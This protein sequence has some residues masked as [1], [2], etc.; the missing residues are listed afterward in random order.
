[1]DVILYEEF[2]QLWVKLHYIAE[3]FETEGSIFE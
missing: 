1:M 2:L 3:T